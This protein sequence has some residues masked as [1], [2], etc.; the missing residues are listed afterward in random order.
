MPARVLDVLFRFVLAPI[1]CVLLIV[2]SIVICL[3][4]GAL[5]RRAEWEKKRVS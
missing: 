3:L 1:A 5:W 4:D 2:A